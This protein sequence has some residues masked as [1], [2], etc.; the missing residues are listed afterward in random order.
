MLTVDLD[1]LAADLIRD[2]G[3]RT[4]AYKDSLGRWTIG[5]GHCI[6]TAGLTVPF[7]FVDDLLAS[8]IASCM[9]EVN[10]GCSW[11]SALSEPRQRVLVEMCF[12]LGIAG[13][14]GFKRM[15]L[16]CQEGRFTDAGIE[17]VTSL[18]GHQEPERVQR[19]AQILG[20]NA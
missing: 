6:D 7:Q 10:A 13:L 9:T 11:A 20:S 12:N 16:A 17:L 14:L 4:T 19:W 8:D 5:V 3:H 15:L 1:T 2:E 18:A